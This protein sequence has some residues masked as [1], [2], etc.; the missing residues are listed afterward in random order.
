MT[1]VH[2]PGGATHLVLMTEDPDFAA[3]VDFDSP[4]RVMEIYLQEMIATTYVQ[5]LQPP[6]RLKAAQLVASAFPSC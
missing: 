2:C 3:D 5:K 4:S 1:W 6:T